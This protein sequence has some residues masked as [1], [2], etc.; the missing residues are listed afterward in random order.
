MGDVDQ[1]R[2]TP[3]VSWIWIKSRLAYIVWPIWSGPLAGY[4]FSVVSGSRFLRGTYEPE[5]S[6]AFSA[7]VGRG[8]FVVDVGAHHGYFSML[9]SHLVGPEGLVFAFEPRPSN[10]HVLRIN[11]RSNR[12][13]NVL[14]RTQAVGSAS[15]TLRFDTQHGSG[16]G[17]LSETGDIEV[18]VIA[19]DDLSL[20]RRPS[21]VK[22]DIEGGEIGALQGARGLIERYRPKLLVAVHGRQTRDSVESLLSAWNYSFSVINPA[23]SKGDT[24]LMAEPL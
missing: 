7:I 24:E 21:F 17:R 20:P 8:D 1:T 23:A 10:I 12:L 15:G 16:T 11:L 13:Q 2:E 9:A 19:L 4:K 6:A 14:V 18:P 22:M 5:K 3:P